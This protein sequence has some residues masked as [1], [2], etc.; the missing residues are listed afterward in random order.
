MLK[1]RNLLAIGIVV[2]MMLAIMTSWA[3]AQPARQDTATPAATDTPAVTD[4][5]AATAV[6]TDTPV[7]TATEVVA[8]A[9]SP[10]STPEATAVSTPSTLPTTGG[11]N[12]GAAGLG[13]IVLVVGALLLLGAFGFAMSHRTR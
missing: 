9:V 12:T 5:P 13:L 10:L 1:Y 6:A 2:V 3:S 8:P 7:P 4:T 11:D